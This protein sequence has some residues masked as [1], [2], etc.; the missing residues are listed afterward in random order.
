V[1]CTT[2]G[3]QVLADDGIRVIAAEQLAKCP[4]IVRI[5]QSFRRH[6]EEF[7]ESL[8]EGV[9]ASIS[10]CPIGQHLL[11][12]GRHVKP[13]KKIS[14][15]RTSVLSTPWPMRIVD[16]DIFRCTGD[17]DVSQP[18]QRDRLDRVRYRE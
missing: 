8:L 6:A 15:R 9:A 14:K 1:D 12:I 3:N 16:S 13:R 11:P 18:A 4:E 10:L 17:R 2:I 5:P 7:D